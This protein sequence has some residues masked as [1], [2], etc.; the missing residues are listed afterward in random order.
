LAQ[1]GVN[2]DEI[3]KYSFCNLMKSSNH[4]I[5]GLKKKLGKRQFLSII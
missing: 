4:E 1:K 3:M 2:F 5:D